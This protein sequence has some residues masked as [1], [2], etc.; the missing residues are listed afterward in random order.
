MQK[1]IPKTIKGRIDVIRF[2]THIATAS[3]LLAHTTISTIYEIT[4]TNCQT[5]PTHTQIAEKTSNG[6]LINDNAPTRHI[7]PEIHEKT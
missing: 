2:T 5:I 3:C 7:V 6:L 1:P 4:Q